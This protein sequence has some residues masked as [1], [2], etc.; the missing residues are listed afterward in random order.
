MFITTLVVLGIYIQYIYLLSSKSIPKI[1]QNS[2]ID[3]S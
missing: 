3:F 1:T 2:I